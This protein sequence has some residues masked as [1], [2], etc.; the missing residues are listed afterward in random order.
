[1]SFE[2]LLRIPLDRV[3]VLIGRKGETKARIE[4]SC[5]VT[6]SIDGQSGEVNVRTTIVGGHVVLDEGRIVGVN[7]GAILTEAQTLAEQLSA[8]AGTRR[9]IEGRWTRQRSAPAASVAMPVN[10]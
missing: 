5:A 7:E 9:R 3:G 10:A 2:R 8:L 6:L 1:M 4:E